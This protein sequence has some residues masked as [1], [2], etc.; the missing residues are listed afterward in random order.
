MHS[1]VTRVA[2]ESWKAVGEGLLDRRG[3]QLIDGDD[4]S[5]EL[6]NRITSPRAEGPTPG[7]LGG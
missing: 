2:Q 6:L 3:R 5:L 7:V 4:S 1:A